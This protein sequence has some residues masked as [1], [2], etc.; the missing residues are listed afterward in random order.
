MSKWICA[1]VS[2]Q[3]GC[4]CV[5]TLS[6][7]SPGYSDTDPVEYFILQNFRDVSLEQH[8]CCPCPV[9]SAVQAPVPSALLLAWKWDDV[10]CSA[11]VLNRSVL[12]STNPS[13]TEINGGVL[14]NVSYLTSV[15][16]SFCYQTAAHGPRSTLQRVLINPSRFIRTDSCVTL[17]TL[18][19]P[20]TEQPVAQSVPLA[21][22]GSTRC[23]LVSA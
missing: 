11:L 6:K 5:D 8:R 12:V 4:G 13:F 1:Y 16:K 15:A 21:P 9:Q 3:L 19:W 2:K 18:I 10:D 7:S 22:R 20:T 14:T 17:R 23:A